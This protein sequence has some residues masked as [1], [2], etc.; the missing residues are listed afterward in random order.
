MKQVLDVTRFVKQPLQ[1]NYY[2]YIKEEAIEE[3][4]CYE[5]N[6]MSLTFM[7]KY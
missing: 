7:F 6:C 1:G 4:D 2:K 5:L 3:K